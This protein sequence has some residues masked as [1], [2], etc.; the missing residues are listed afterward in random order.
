MS[1]IKTFAFQDK[2]TVKLGEILAKE[3][4]ALLQGGTGTGK[5]YIVGQF[6]RDYIHKLPRAPGPR[7]LWVGPAA[8][9]IQ[10]RR[11]L[12]DIGVL[13]RLA[14]PET[15]AIRGYK[16]ISYSS[17]TSPKT[18]G[19]LFWDLVPDSNWAQTLRYEWN[20]ILRPDL[21]VFDECQALKNDSSS[22]TAIARALPVDVKRIFISATP[23]QRPSEARTVMGGVGVRGKS[24][25]AYNDSNI[26][27]LLTTDCSRYGDPY[28]YSPAA[29]ER[30]RDYMDPY[31]VALKGIRF[32]FKARSECVLIDFDTEDARKEYIRAYEDYLL[33]LFKTKGWTGHS[34]AAARLVAMQKFRQKAEELRGPEVARR[35]YAKVTKEGKAVII[36][37]NFKDMLRA[38]IIKLRELGVSDDRM[39]FIHGGQTAEKRQSSV[40][41]FQ[42][43]ETSYMLMTMASGG[44]GISLHH[45]TEQAKP[46]HI[47][48]P[49]TWS[50]IDLIQALGRSHRLT[51]LSD[52]T[53][54]IL[55]YRN[56][57]EG[58]VAS[59]VQQKTRCLNKAVQAREQWATLFVPK[60]DN[61]GSDL[62]DVDA[63]RDADTDYSLD[64]GL[65]AD[66]QE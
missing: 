61:L 38:A 40:D 4:G 42:S 53:Q 52:T 27:R 60:E 14:T 7:V 3:N 5:T 10:T 19:E 24:G 33:V 44:V 50:A 13:H 66:Q 46:R 16:V 1:K 31:T 56:T 48:L 63:D 6:L 17:L 51:S 34:A 55:W 35:A 64:A 45:E 18:G 54:E 62:G 25:V 23:Y 58:D 43:G 20:D 47:I 57:I 65:L 39:S 29:M 26:W 22:R 37:S 59:V 32:K 41:R 8:T 21:V 28:A 49:P 2:A 9:I 12:N 11:V 15:K 30:V 36:A